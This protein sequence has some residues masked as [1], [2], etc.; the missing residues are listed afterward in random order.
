MA[1]NCPG[2]G[3]P[4]VYDPGFDSLVCE[5]C[6]NI[7]DPQTLPDADDFYLNQG[8]EPESLEDLV[9]EEELT[10]EMY[11]CHIY[12]CSQCGGEVIVSGTEA[13]TR[14]M[15]CGSTAVV[16]NR[17]AQERRPDYIVP[18]KVTKEEAVEKVLHQ[19]RSGLFVPKHFK[20]TEPSVV[21][22]IY[23][24]Y[25]LYDGEIKDTQRFSIGHTEHIY[26]GECGFVDL[27]VEACKSLS[28]RTSIQLDPFDLREKVPFDTSY[29]M[30]FYS[31]VKDLEPRAGK[32]IAE[33]KARAFLTRAMD[34]LTPKGNV[35]MEKKIVT[36]VPKISTTLTSTA[37]L[38]VWFITIDRQGTPYTFLVNGQT[39]KVV[40]TVPWN[41]FLAGAMIVTIFLALAALSTLLLFKS[42]LADILMRFEKSFLLDSS[43]GSAPIYGIGLFIFFIGSATLTFMGFA[44]AK[45]KNILDKLNLSRSIVTFIFSK[46]RQGDAK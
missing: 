6:G 30:G 9:E 3:A 15:Y 28:D 11:D 5:T 26:D 39:G 1:K 7:I 25:Y 33:M 16:F 34:E 32:G 21:R 24:P 38:P 14:C 17:I 42:G 13:S 46:K 40:G 19:L 35:L 27:P 18:F 45:F 44:F 43:D 12:K 31:N 4:M 10:G 22:G 23:I 20:V 2:C 36:S 37:L 29:L 8:E 41:R